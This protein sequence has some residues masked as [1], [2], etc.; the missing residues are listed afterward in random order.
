M[1]SF[2]GLLLNRGV[3][4]TVA[5]IISQAWNLYSYLK[6]ERDS[7]LSNDETVEFSG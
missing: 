1:L 2:T 4:V 6:E 7:Y 5:V 3:G